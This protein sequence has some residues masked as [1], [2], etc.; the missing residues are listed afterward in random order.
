MP[1]DK[2]PDKLP[3]LVDGRNDLDLESQSDS[4]A[5]QCFWSNTRRHLAA[6][7]LLTAQP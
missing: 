2:L 1:T 5:L 4:T 3:S 7:K 6:T